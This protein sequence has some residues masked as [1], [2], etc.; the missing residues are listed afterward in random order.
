[1]TGRLRHRPPLPEAQVVEIVTPRTTAA[2]GT[3]V[4]NL[5]AAARIPGARCSL[6]IAASGGIC[7]FLV[8]TGNMSMQQ[9]LCAQLSAAYP[10]ADLRRVVPADDPAVCRA[11]EQV[12]GC[13]LAV[14][15]PP[16][17]PL[18]VWYDNTL[19]G[20][21]QAQ[22]DPLLGVLAALRVLPP[23]WRGLVQLVL[24]PAPANWGAPYLRYAAEPRQPSQ[25]PTHATTATSMA[26]VWL[27]AGLMVV[28][29]IALQ[30]YRWYRSGDLLH[31]GLLVA[32]TLLALV[33]LARVL[34]ARLRDGTPVPDRQQV[35]EKLRRAAYATQIRL[36]V[37]APAAE[38][39]AAVQSQLL[40][41]AAAFTPYGELT[42]CVLVPHPLRLGRQRLNT[43]E[44]LKCGR[45][46]VPG[47]G[48]TRSSILTTRELAALW[49]LPHQAADVPLLER[50]GARRLLPLPWTV[51]TGCRI[52]QA[53]HNGIVVPVC[54]P[55]G[56][57]RRHLL[58]VARTGRGKSS[59]LLCIVRYLLQICDP[60]K[61]PA[62]VLVDPHRDLALAA[63]GLVPAGREDAVVYLDAAATD[64]PF[65][66]NLLD[67]GLGWSREGAVENTIAI[68]KAQFAEFWGPRMEHALRHALLTLYSANESL[69]AADPSGGRSRQY[70]L[71]D[72]PALLTVRGF[73]QS[74][75]AT[76]SDRT[77]VAWWAEYYEALPPSFRAEVIDPVQTKITRFAASRASRAILGQPRSTIDLDAVV[78]QRGILIVNTAKG[79]IGQDTAALI[80]GTLLNLVALATAA[81]AKLP[82]ERRVPVT[83]LV[84]EFHTLPSVDYEGILSEFKK[85]GGNLI[86]ATQSLAR[87]DDT[88]GRMQGH[89]LRATLFA[90]VDGLLA[91]NVSAEDAAY[92]V[93]ELGGEVE[94]TDLVRLG[95]HECY[96]RLLVDGRTLPPCWVQ[97]DPPPAVSTAECE[98]R[99]AA[100]SARSGRAR[101]AVDADL[102]AARARI[103]AACGSATWTSGSGRAWDATA[104]PVEAQPVAGSGKMPRNYK[105]NG[106]RRQRQAG[107][108]GADGTGA[109]PDSQEPNTTGTPRGTDG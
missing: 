108:P 87:L 49:H 56:L 92:L 101:A 68:L 8:R 93:P 30:A 105:R 42:G 12:A 67:T 18:R 65:G 99:A 47:G 23:G 95:E 91:F 25:S 81:Q 97:L 14:Q 46:F 74:V 77:L 103:D 16:Y 39:P 6:E 61:Q 29:L 76:L 78:Q 28:V 96:A 38:S 20:E 106:E 62:L 59:V 98:Q 31:L 86:L 58:L 4:E 22:S 83:L 43:P 36:A 11:G 70:T 69:C 71:L 2:T 55:D 60:D 13:L 79:I 80:G 33:V 51:A 50:T 104:L 90:N 63:L 35:Q 66:L 48:T 9:Q 52:G 1:M 41:V 100:A 84:D 57:L 88:A 3:P 7:R 53:E 24:Q 10:Q 109:A 34:V 85:Y 5:L 102:Q 17:L 73:R 32:G 94:V 15:G 72:I 54:L 40:Q 107:T 19:D 89:A 82:R 45:R 27:L 44:P 75:L 21:R 64:R 26:E 37:I